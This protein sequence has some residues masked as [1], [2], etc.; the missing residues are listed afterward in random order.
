MIVAIFGA[1]GQLGSALLQNAR[2]RQCEIASPPRSLDVSDNDGVSVYLAQIR[3]D[4]IIN[5]AA[6]TD[7]DY[8]EGNPDQC[9]MVNGL[10]A[11]HL[12]Q[13]ANKHGARFV[14][15]STEAV[16]SGDLARPYTETDAQTPVSI[17]G[18]SK[19]LAEELTRIRNADAYIIRTS[20]LYSNRKAQNFPTRLIQNLS[21]SQ[22]TVDVVTD[23]IGNPTPVE[24]LSEAIFA[25][26]SAPPKPGTYHVCCLEGVSKFDW[27][28]QIAN[29]F[30][31]DAGRL[32]P[33]LAQDY[34]T[35][36]RR[37]LNVVLD[38]GK[39]MDSGVFALPTWRGAWDQWL[40]TNVGGDVAAFLDE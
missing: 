15:L 33:V 39:F 23:V 8:A 25:L 7:V 10:A 38:C 9:V 37:P 12:A 35:K 20:W 18:A 34:P 5:A 11:G 24:T 30:G 40:A 6:L 16:F 2:H 1:S 19:V 4:W 28:V 32:N 22:Q 29:S 3:P 17:Y 14:Q 13:E 27:A 31:F 36:A 21:I 26:M